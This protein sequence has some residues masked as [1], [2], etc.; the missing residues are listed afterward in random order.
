MDNI[1]WSKTVGNWGRNGDLDDLDKVEEKKK[2]IVLSFEE[3]TNAKNE[4]ITIC[5]E[6]VEKS[7]ILYHLFSNKE[8]YDAI[9]TLRS[10][11][12]SLNLIH[13]KK[14]KSEIKEEV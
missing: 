2:E 8:L 11:Q 1:S 4:I 9:V 3:K 14:V 6:L 5:D 12:K 13:I 7:E 10:A